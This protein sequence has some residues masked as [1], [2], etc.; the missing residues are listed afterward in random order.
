MQTLKEVRKQT[1]LTQIQ[2]AKLCGVSRRTFQTYEEKGNIA[3]AYDEI[4][5]KLKE[6]GINDKGPAILNAKFIK[7]ATSEI[8][9]KYQEVECAYLFGSYARG[10][11][12]SDSDVDILIV[13]PTISGFNLGGLHYELRMKLRKDVDLITH[14]VILNDERMLRDLL[15]QGVKIYGQRTGFTKD[16]SDS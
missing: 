7:N 14:K 5:N 2:A 4:L 6:L 10:E 16:W 13:A 11:A 12:T 3:I 15:K 9:A 1:G 8:F